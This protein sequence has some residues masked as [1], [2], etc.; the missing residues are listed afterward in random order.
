MNRPPRRRIKVTHVEFPSGAKSTT[1]E[2]DGFRMVHLEGPY[3][4]GDLIDVLAKRVEP[5][6]PK[7]P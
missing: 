4:E 7:K 5:K 2:G 6:E 3:H 1:I